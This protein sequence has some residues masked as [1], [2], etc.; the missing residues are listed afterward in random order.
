MKY[1]R[2]VDFV[3]LRTTTKLRA[4][5]D[6]YMLRKD[7]PAQWLQR[8][9]LFILRK[10]G[11]TAQTETTEVRRVRLDGEKF[12]ARLFQQKEELFHQFG[13]EPCKL[14]IGSADYED[15]MGTPEIHH[16]MRFPA[17]YGIGNTIADLDVIVVPWMRG[18]V[19][20]PDKWA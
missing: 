13:Y 5:P 7:R 3:T 18:M 12:I 10:L 11:A 4:V 19:V 16:I 20:I 6:A 15:L 9:C 14:L 1:I 2:E 8:V 17:A